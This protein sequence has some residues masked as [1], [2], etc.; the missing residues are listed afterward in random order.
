MMLLAAFAPGVE[1]E[2]AN[3]S[4]EAMSIIAAPLRTKFLRFT[5]NPL[6]LVAI[7]VERESGA[8]VQ[9]DAPLSHV[10]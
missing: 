1:D 7:W 9:I 5:G 2:S 3:L 4:E 6:Q 10:S 8:V